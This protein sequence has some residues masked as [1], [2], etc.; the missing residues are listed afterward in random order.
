[1]QWTLPAEEEQFDAMFTDITKYASYIDNTMEKGQV[2]GRWR[3]FGLTLAWQEHAS[4]FL[5][6]PKLRICENITC[7]T[8]EIPPKTGVYVSSEYPDGALQ[9]AWNGNE[10]G[11]VLEC[12]IFNDL[13][14]KALTTVGR[15]KLW[16]DKEAML[17]FVQKNANAQELKEDSFYSEA[18]IPDLAPSLVARNAFTSAPS[19]WCYVE[20]LE[21]EFEDIDPET[22]QSEH[23]ERRV[24]ANKHCETSGFYFSPASPG[25]RRFFSQGDIFP[26][27]DSAY[28][29]TIWQWDE[30]Q[31]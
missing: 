10:Y 9:F 17:A 23:Q 27:L 11:E 3:D 5:K 4:R 26:K 14:Q 22:D 28:G 21:G 8:G 13:G 16:L 18:F 12:S 1:M 7:K 15:Q 25:S 29:N 31:D 19:K 6:L 24:E 2:D 20:L 30:K